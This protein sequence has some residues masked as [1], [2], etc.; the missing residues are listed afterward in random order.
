MKAKEDKA[1]KK[2]GTIAPQKQIGTPLPEYLPISMLNQLEYYRRRFWYMYVQ[3][4][5]AV[6]APVL[7][8]QL[9][10][11]QAN[12]P[13]VSRE[14]EGLV[15]RRAYVHSER[16]RLAGF[17]DL[18]EERSGEVH[19]VE[20]KHGRTGKWLNDHIQLCAQALCLEEGLGQTVPYGFIFYWGSRR[21]QRVEFTLEL[22]RKTEAAVALAFA[23]LEAGQLPPPLTNWSKCR[24]CS[25]EPI[26]LPREVLQ[27]TPTAS[28]PEGDS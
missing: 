16:L 24:D 7:E 27:L 17:L 6:N 10:H 4:E 2:P 5:M 8:G 19:P 25:L 18:L 20:Y 28:G 21:R 22:R 15:I 11:Q 13:G 9:Q 23:L 14:D 26:C 12:T 3:G 1:M